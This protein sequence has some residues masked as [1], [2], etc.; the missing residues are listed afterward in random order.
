VA[1]TRAEFTGF[2][3]IPVLHKKKGQDKNPSHFN[4]I[5]YEKPG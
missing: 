1:A 4:P 2:F 5:F 3:S